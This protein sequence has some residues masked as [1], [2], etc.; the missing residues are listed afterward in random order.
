MDDSLKRPFAI[1][2]R[3]LGPRPR[4]EAELRLRL[5]RRGFDDEV[6]SS[7]LAELKAQRL[8]DDVAFA[9]FWRGNREHFSPRSRRLLEQELRGKGVAPEV[10]AEVMAGLD[11][12]IESRRAAERQARQLKGL[13]YHDFYKKLNAF[14]KRRG[15]DHDVVEH[16]INQV[17]KE[18]ST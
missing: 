4:S 15:F 18:V 14:L 6:I 3:Y 17:G 8:V 7:V 1:A 12:E 5:R 9:Q 11:D 16:A 2:L 10:I 13:D